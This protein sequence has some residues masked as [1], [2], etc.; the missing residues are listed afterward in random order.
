M[1]QMRPLHTKQLQAIL[2]IVHRNNQATSIKINTVAI[3]CLQ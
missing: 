1:D 3:I 2:N